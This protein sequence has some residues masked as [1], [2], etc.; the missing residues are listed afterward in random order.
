MIKLNN[1][2]FL[3]LILMRLIQ[4]QLLDRIFDDLRLRFHLVRS[5]IEFCIV[6]FDILAS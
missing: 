4:P 6:P 1:R 2:K 5:C 3:S